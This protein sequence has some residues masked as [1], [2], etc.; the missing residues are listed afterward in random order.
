MYFCLLDFNDVRG[1]RLFVE[2]NTDIIIL[3]CTSLLV[4]N[5]VHAIHSSK[6]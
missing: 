5:D 6:N 4:L 2:K 3:E 1:T